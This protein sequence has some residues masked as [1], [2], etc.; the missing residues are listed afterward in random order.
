VDSPRTGPVF[1]PRPQLKADY[2]E[3][4]VTVTASPEGRL[5]T[6]T[7]KVTEDMFNALRDLAAYDHTT[8]SEEIRRALAQYLE[9]RRAPCVQRGRMKVCT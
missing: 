8:V 6:V 7:V 3:D 5:V 9:G 2:E 1:S 4:G